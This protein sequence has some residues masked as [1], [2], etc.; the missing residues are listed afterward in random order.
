MTIINHRIKF[1][2]KNFFL[3]IT[4][5]FFEFFYL[6]SAI[7]SFFVFCIYSRA[8]PLLWRYT[9]V[10]RNEFGPLPG[11]SFN[12]LECDIH[13]VYTAKDLL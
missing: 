7:Y 8:N 4:K 12:I 13:V 3:S 1:N 2:I 9:Q 10:H 11:G 6:F 5:L